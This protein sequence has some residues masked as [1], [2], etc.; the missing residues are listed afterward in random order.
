MSKHT[1]NH[2]ILILIRGIPGSG[3]SYLARALKEAIGQDQVVTLD[4]DATDY[5]SKEY[6]DMSNSLTAEGVDAKLHPYRFLR[7]NAYKG[8]ETNKVVMWN[9]AFTNLDGF[10]KTVKNLQAYAEEHGTTLPVL[11]V[12][13]EVTEHVAKKR[14]SDRE[15]QGGHGVND[16]AFARFLNEYTTFASKGYNIVVVNGEDDVADSVAS[17]LA[18][19]DLLQK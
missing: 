12:E 9:Q 19:F 4:P 2:P 11:V 15:Q 16:D 10:E 1:V 3:K 7:G 13:V 8:I 18:S 5:T 17:V 6:V 14:V